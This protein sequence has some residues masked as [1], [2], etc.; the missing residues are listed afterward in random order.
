M[1]EHKEEIFIAAWDEYLKKV[2]SSYPNVDPEK[3][4]E[5]KEEM[6]RRNAAT[7]VAISDTTSISDE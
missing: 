5:L 6:K 1:E 3:C 4:L 2:R 7:E